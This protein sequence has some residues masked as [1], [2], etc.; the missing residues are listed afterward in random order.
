MDDAPRIYRARWV[1]PVSAPPI[2]N[3]VVEIRGSQI[4][5]V[6]PAQGDE[7]E[8]L[9]YTALIPGLV[10]AHTHLEFS[11]LPQQIRPPRP[12]TSWIRALVQA[13]RAGA[14]DLSTGLKTGYRESARAGTTLLGEIATPGWS[15]AHWAGET[16]PRVVAFRELLGLRQDQ[17]ETQLQAA[18]DF[19]DQPHEPELIR[20]LSPHAPY[21]VHPELYRRLVDLAATRNVPLAVHLAE[22]P[23]ELELLAYG[24]GEFVDMLTEFGVWE[25]SVIPTGTRPLDYLKPLAKLDRALVIH[26]NYL[27]DE[28]LEFLAQHPQITVVYCP[29]T[30]AWFGHEP[31]RWLEMLERGVSLA[32]GTDSRASNPDLSLWQ[33]LLFLRDNFRNVPGE[34]LLQLGTLAGASAI[35]LSDRHGTLQPGK[36]ADLALVA[37]DSLDEHNPHAALLDWRSTIVATMHAGQWV[38]E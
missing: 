3:G 27:D 11:Q 21:S 32:L 37:V 13:R 29:R 36:Q 5:D 28:E 30:H 8:Y 1:F 16:G 24:T 10:N 25:P 31:H 15:T 20:G 18:A 7:G 34:Q 2:E 38:T 26:A 12:F 19:L 35:G 9:G 33:E 23:S 14:V 22:T 17:I 6:R 4:A